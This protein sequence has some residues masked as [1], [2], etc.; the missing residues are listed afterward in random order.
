MKNI[1]L[2]NLLPKNQP[3]TFSSCNQLGE[4]YFIKILLI[5]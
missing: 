1:A 2:I 4:I 5:I 3:V